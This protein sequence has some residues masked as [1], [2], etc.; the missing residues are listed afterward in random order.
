MVRFL[1]SDEQRRALRRWHQA[2]PKSIRQIDVINWFERQYGHRIRQSTVSDSLSKKYQFLDTSAQKPR[3]LQGNWPILETILF[4]WQQ[5][6]E[7]QG[8][9]ITGDILISQARAIWPQI[10]D[11]FNLPIP[12]FS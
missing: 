11:Y 6:I 2:Q 10:P 9:D 4:D 12:E 8:G 3:L 5:N 7:N 1:I